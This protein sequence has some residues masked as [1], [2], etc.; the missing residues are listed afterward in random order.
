MMTRTQKGGAIAM[1]TDAQ[2]PNQLLVL[3]PRLEGWPSLL[4]HAE[5]GVAVL[6]LDPNM[7]GLAQI[8]DV[9]AELGPLS[10]IHI[11]D[12]GA[13]GRL[14]LGACI[15][16]MDTLADR[17]ADLR[18]L[19]DGLAPGGALLLWGCEIGQ[20]AT[21]GRFVAALSRLLARD[22]AASDDST[23][24]RHLGGDWELEV[25]SGRVAVHPAHAVAATALEAHPVLL[26]PKRR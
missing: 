9:A 2:A 5:Q 26:T 19:G 10:A 1:P 11:A 7:D 21:G 14:R 8:A 20:G 12:H 13:P 6:V 18:K 17:V 16:D 23:G 22:V 3:D 24:P 4:A 15:L 25:V